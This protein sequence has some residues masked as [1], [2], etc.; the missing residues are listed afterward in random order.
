MNRLGGDE[1][2]ADFDQYYCDCGSPVKIVVYVDTGDYFVICAYRTC[3]YVKFL[4]PGV[5]TTKPNYFDV[6]EPMGSLSIDR[7][8]RL[9]T[10]SRWFGYGFSEKFWTSLAVEVPGHPFPKGSIEQKDDYGYDAFISYRGATGRWQ[11][12]KNSDE[13]FG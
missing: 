9:S 2:Y 8:C 13:I 3:R 1:V 5:Y 6:D 4:A 11:L 7:Y 10:I 12:K